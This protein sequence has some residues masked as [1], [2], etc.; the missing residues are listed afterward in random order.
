[1]AAQPHYQ[2]Q[3]QLL[4]ADEGAFVTQPGRPVSFLTG[5]FEGRTIRVELEE[6]QKA[7]SGRKL[8]HLLFALWITSNNV[9][10]SW[11]RY[12]RVDRRPLDPPPVIK[13]RL[14]YVTN[15]GTDKEREREVGN[16]E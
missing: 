4:G 9:N 3:H 16:Y 6:L 1:M 11:I 5:Q 7:E 12:A 8:V 13:L 15:P 10:L 14:F 2:D